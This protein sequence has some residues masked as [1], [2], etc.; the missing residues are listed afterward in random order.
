MKTQLGSGKV[1]ER[2]ERVFVRAI[3]VIGSRVLNH[4]TK[5]N[6]HTFEIDVLHN[7]PASYMIEFL[8]RMNWFLSF[9]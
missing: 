6:Q 2:G 7:I 5:L 8:E 4:Q 3:K 9:K 1:T